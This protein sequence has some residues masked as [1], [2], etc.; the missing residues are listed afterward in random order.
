MQNIQL[1]FIH[2]FSG[3]ERDQKRSEM[4]QIEPNLLEVFD[5]FLKLTRQLT[6]ILAGSPMDDFFDGPRTDGRV[7]NQAL[8]V[9][10]GVA[11]VMLGR[12]TIAAGF[13]SKSRDQSIF[14]G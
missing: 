6:F 3:F 13:A 12:E 9:F 2:I 5:R 14:A 10:D 8:V 1:R 11:F 4:T 7:S